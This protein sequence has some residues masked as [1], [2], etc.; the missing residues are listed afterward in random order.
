VCS[1]P[2]GSR[3]A[4]PLGTSWAANGTSCVTTRSPAVARAA[5]YA[6]A[7]V[8]ASVHPHGRHQRIPG[9]RLKPLIRDQDSLDVQAFGRSKYQLFDF[10]GC[11]VGI[12]PDLQI[13]PASRRDGPRGPE[14]SPLGRA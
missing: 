3:T 11:R 12:N 2:R 14:T 1:S 10:P 9:R 6:S 13:T 8:R 7:H 5:M 4:M